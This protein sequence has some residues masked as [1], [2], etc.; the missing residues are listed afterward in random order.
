MIVSSPDVTGQETFGSDAGD[1][2]LAT[3][4][5]L[6]NDL[7]DDDEDHNVLARIL[8]VDPPS[9]EQLRDSHVSEFRV[10]ASRLRGIVDALVKGDV[11]RGAQRVNELLGEHSAQPHLAKDNGV[12]RLHHHPAE[13]EPTAIWTAITA[14]A[15]ARL[16]GDGRAERIGHCEAADCR[17]V[18]LDQSRNT[19]RRFCTTTCQNRVKAAAFRSRQRSS[20]TRS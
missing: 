1:V 8:S 15:L 4:L 9:L 11:D 20:S 17:R 14:D 2:G 12:W 6:V 18:F 10:L 3:V 5:A 7:T 19:S 16:I 13:A